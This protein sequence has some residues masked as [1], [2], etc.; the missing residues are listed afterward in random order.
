ML[1]SCPAQS[2]EDAERICEALRSAGVVLRVG[3]VVYLRPQEVTEMILRVCACVLASCKI[4]PVYI[5]NNSW[6]VHGSGDHDSRKYT[7]TATCLKTCSCAGAA[8][9]R[10]GGASTAAGAVCRDRSLGRAEA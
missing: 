6:C 2:A 4:G 3:N 5:L 8:R 9:Y 10:G 1:T 7:S